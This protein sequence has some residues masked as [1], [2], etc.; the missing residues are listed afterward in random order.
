M[1][2][3][4]GSYVKDKDGVPVLRER[5]GT[6]VTTEKPKSTTKEVTKQ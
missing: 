1:A 6:V 2:R 3:Q 5:T 4:G